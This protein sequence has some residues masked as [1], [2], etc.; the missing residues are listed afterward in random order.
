MEMHLQGFVVINNK[1][2]DLCASKHF[3]DVSLCAHNTV[4]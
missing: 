1:N 3:N 2:S 4:G